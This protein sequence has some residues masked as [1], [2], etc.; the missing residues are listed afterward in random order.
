MR[1]AIINEV[2]GLTLA[3]TMLELVYAD[4]L[5]LRSHSETITVMDKLIE[6]GFSGRELDAAQIHGVETDDRPRNMGDLRTGSHRK[7][8]E[9]KLGQSSSYRTA[10]GCIRSPRCKDYTTAV[11]LQLILT[12]INEARS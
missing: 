10:R 8:L 9:T 6:H 3:Q 1:D 12:R 7:Y 11:K 5:P 2:A 4:V